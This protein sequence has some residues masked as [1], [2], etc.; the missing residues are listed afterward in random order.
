MDVPPSD[1]SRDETYHRGRKRGAAAAATVVISGLCVL[2]VCALRRWRPA[3]VEVTGD[4]MV[5][6]LLPG[7]RALAVAAGSPRRGDIVV[8]EHPSRPGFELVKRVRSTPGD[9]APDGRI[10]GPGELWVEGDSPAR[11]TDSRQLGPVGLDAVRARLL[12][13][14]RPPRRWRVLRTG[15]PRA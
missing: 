6:T 1:G 7:D 10:L 4:S 3:S 2:V 14:Y 11:S 13:V 5:P 15:R 12:L 8:I 9:L